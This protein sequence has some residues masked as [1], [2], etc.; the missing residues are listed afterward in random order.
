MKNNR[1]ESH[2]FKIMN[3]VEGELVPATL[4]TPIV[5]PNLM[6]IKKYSAIGQERR[7]GLLLRH[8]IHNNGPPILRAV[9]GIQ[10]LS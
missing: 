10:M 2:K 9:Q 6:I 8:G 5:L 7:K 1:C 4:M 3:A